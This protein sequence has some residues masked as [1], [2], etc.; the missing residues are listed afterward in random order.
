MKTANSSYTW[1]MKE[2][3][4]SLK[5][6]ATFHHGFYLGPR[7]RFMWPWI[8]GN[9][10]I[11]FLN[12]NP[13]FT[14]IHSSPKERRLKKSC[15]SF[16][17]ECIIYNLQGDKR[18]RV[19]NTRNSLCMDGTTWTLLEKNRHLSELNSFY[20]L[21]RINYNVT[22]FILKSQAVL[23]AILCATTKNHR[24]FQHPKYG[25]WPEVTTKYVRFEGF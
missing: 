6:N 24:N 2:Y 13:I 19:D 22:G 23:V 21:Q 15:V 3:T 10:H 9:L 20:V 16:E 25:L 11:G 17:T 14:G 1:C 5:R 18:E 8:I 4:L 7:V 12:N